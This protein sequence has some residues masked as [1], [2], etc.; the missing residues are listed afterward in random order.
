MT[1]AADNNVLTERFFIYTYTVYLDAYGC[2]VNLSAC[3]RDA[4]DSGRTGSKHF[5]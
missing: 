5:F 3:V 1:L 2:N 4:R